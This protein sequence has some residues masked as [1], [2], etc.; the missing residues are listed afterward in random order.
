RREQRFGGIHS[1]EA[2][3]RSRLQ[4]RRPRAEELLVAFVA[5]QTEA[6]SAAE[7]ATEFAAPRKVAHVGP[8]PLD[9]EPLPRGGLPRRFQKLSRDIDAGQPVTAACEIDRQAAVAAR[10]VENARA[11]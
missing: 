9:G 5:Q 2:D 6:R 1:G 3:P 8:A 11:E 4:R 10:H 7:G